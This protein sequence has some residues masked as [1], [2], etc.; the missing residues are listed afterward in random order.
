MKRYRIKASGSG[1]YPD[2]DYEA[3]KY[4]YNLGWMYPVIEVALQH[5]VSLERLKASLK[6]DK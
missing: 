2:L 5:P 4:P 6:D 3:D 1:Q